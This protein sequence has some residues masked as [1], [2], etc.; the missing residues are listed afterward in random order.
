MANT[1]FV[2]DMQQHYVP[3][4][5]YK[6]VGKSTEYD[7]AVGMK[8]LSKAYELIVDIEGHLKWMDDAGIDMGILSTAALAGSGYEFCRL[9]NEGYAEVVRKYP[10]RFRGVIHV[11]PFDADRKNPDEIRRGVE[12]LG[13]WGIG[14]VTST[15]NMTL[16]SN[17]MDAIYELAIG[18]DMPVYVHPTIR[19]GLWGGGKYDLDLTLAREY[20]IAKSFAEI[21]YGVL[22][23][24]PD[25]KVIFAHFGGGLSTLKGRLLAWHQPEDFPMPEADRGHGLA[26]EEAR[27]LGLVD[28]FESLLKNMFFD[29]AGFGGWLPVMKSAM[30]VLGPDHICFGTDYPYELRDPKYVKETIENIMTIDAPNEDKEKFLGANLKTLF[31]I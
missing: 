23:R 26:V 24:F 20:E 16:D 5:A 12:E 1:P 11:Y 13:L 22:P 27:D 25:L 7:H 6:R 15:A 19:R 28:D 3:P 18:Y 4:Q 8:R 2:I 21:I 29:S 14:V 9:C 30:E 17:L 31:R 10:D